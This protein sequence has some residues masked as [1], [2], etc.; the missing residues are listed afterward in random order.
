VGEIEVLILIET[1]VVIVVDHSIEDEIVL[2]PQENTI[3]G[4]LQHI[5]LIVHPHRFTVSTT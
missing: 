3:I 4:I 5:H 2:A 1:E